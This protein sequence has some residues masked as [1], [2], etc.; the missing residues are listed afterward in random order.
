MIIYFSDDA[1]IH[2]CLGLASVATVV[3]AWGS[4][5]W[6]LASPTQGKNKILDHLSVHALPGG[7]QA[8]SK[9]NLQQW[10]DNVIMMIT[11]TNTL[12]YTSNGVRQWGLYHRMLLNDY[13]NVASVLSTA[14]Q[15]WGSDCRNNGLS[16]GTLYCIT[17]A[18]TGNMTIAQHVWGPFI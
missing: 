3:G 10:L 6:H 15:T 16:C 1:T 12:V 17:G 9:S 18:G 7:T 8:Q 2:S 14:L 5:P 13:N 4:R 11:T